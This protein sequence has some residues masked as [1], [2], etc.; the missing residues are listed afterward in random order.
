MKK[1]VYGTEFKSE[2]A[3]L[4]YQRENIK[5]LTND[6]GVQVQPIYKWK[7]VQKKRNYPQSNY[8][9]STRFFGD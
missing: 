3:R 1:R 5:E 2:G 8:K 6:L 4:S 7:A 9:T